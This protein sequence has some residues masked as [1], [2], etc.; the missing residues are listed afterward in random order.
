M[1]SRP[2]KNNPEQEVN[3]ADL[4]EIRQGRGGL[5]LHR[6]ASPAVTFPRQRFIVPVTGVHMKRYMPLV[7]VLSVL[8]L[9]AVATA[10][11]RGF[12]GAVGGVTF[13]TE[14]SS[15]FGAQ[16]GAR[17]APSLFVFG[18]IG[19]M[20]N[21]LPEDLQDELDLA[22]D[23]FELEFGTAMELDA[24]VPAFYGLAG[25]RWSRNA[26]VTPF[27]EGAVG[28][29][30]LSLDLDARVGGMDVSSLIEDALEEE[31]TEATKF[32]LA[33][34]GGINARLI[35]HLRLD[36]G[37]RYSRIFTDDPAINTSQVYAAVKFGF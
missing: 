35:E 18:E 33:I 17:I 24:R 27:V 3:G 31:D 23:L 13:V 15:I 1:F 8:V 30:R 11:D 20:Q 10:Q 16:V 28:F 5:Q 34:G 4:P 37:Y 7:F 32:L 12:V 6:C 29:A 14:T 26:R 21:V 25:I 2:D 22:A 9:P 19:R 36:V